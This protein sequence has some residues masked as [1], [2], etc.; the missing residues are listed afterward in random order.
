MSHP[1]LTTQFHTKTKVC[2]ECEGKGQLEY[3]IAVPM[4]FSNPYGYL[5]LC[6]DDCH[7]CGG[8][9]YIEEDLD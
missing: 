5:D 8:S 3:E 9:G 1:M 6:W 4:G 7:E 2:G